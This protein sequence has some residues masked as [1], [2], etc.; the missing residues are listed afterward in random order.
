ARL[1]SAPS[2]VAGVR[3]RRL[4]RHPATGT[5][6]RAT[7]PAMRFAAVIL[8]LAAWGARTTL[9]SGSPTAGCGPSGQGG[10]D[11]QDNDCNGLVDD[12]VCDCARFDLATG[13]RVF[14]CTDPLP[15]TLA[16]DH[17]HSMGNHL[18]TIRS[19]T[20]DQAVFDAVN[21]LTHEK[22]WIGLNDR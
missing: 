7:I 11:G 18:V 2:S 6:R 4:S 8:V 13:R 5:R 20:E 19:A 15:W 16:R 17:C 12:G 9:D 21:L 1:A 22:Y 14:V 10:C 3:G